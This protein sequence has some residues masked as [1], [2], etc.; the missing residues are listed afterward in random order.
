MLLSHEKSVISPADGP[1]APLPGAGFLKS[2]A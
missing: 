1:A 2:T